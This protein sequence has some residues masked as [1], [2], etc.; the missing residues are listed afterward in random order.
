MVMFEGCFFDVVWLCVGIVVVCFNDL[1]I[2]KLLSG[3]FDCFKCYGVDVLEISFQFDVVW[4]LG[5]FELLIVVQQMVCFGQYQVLI[6]FGV[7]ICGD[8]FYFDVVVVEVSK[9]VVVVVCDMLVFVIFGVLIIDMMQQVLEWVG[10]KSNFGWSYGLEVL[11][12]GSLMW[13]LLLV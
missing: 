1:V 3:C 12:M 9:G 4:V 5:F 7:V 13:F 11:E 8:M 6:I 2:V 10:I